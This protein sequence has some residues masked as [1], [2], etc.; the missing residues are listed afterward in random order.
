MKF[1]T[2]R[3]TSTVLPRARRGYQSEKHSTEDARERVA[4]QVAAMRAATE[5]LSRLAAVN[6]TASSAGA[7]VV[8]AAT[9]AKEVLAQKDAFYFSIAGLASFAALRPEERAFAAVT[10]AASIDP[11]FNFNPVCP[12]PMAS[13]APGEGGT[14]ARGSRQH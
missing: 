10:S 3:A 7:Q 5:E 6:G 8:D 13:S 11:F 1:R 9:S 4:F 12:A 14:G 2:A